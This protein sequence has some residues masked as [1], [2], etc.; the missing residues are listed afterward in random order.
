MSDSSS[1]NG[2][3]RLSNVSE[4]KNFTSTGR[5]ADMEHLGQ[6]EHFTDGSFTTEDI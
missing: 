4:K 5:V 1:L 6:L 3:E 2:S